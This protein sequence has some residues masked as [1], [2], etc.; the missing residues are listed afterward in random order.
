MCPNLVPAGVQRCEECLALL[1]VCTNP[2]VRRA[3]AYEPDVR[4]ATLLLLSQ[5]DDYSV[6]LTAENILDVRGRSINPL[7]PFNP[8]AAVDNPFGTTSRTDAPLPWDLT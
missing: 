2:E 6:A 5:D 8:L 1:I 4:E 7:V 3:L